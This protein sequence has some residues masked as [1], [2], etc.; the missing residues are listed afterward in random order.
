MAKIKLQGHASGSGIITLT[1]PNTSTDRVI[2]LPDATA[3]IATTTD[4]AA[5]LP[6]ITDGGNATAITIDSSERVSIG[7]TANP[8]SSSLHAKNGLTVAD[9]SLVI[10]KPDNNTKNWR[11]LPNNNLYD[12]CIQCTTGTNT[13]ETT[14]ATSYASVLELRH[15]GRGLSQFTAKAWANFN[16]TG[17]PAFRDSHNFSSLTDYATGFA[18]CNFT[19]AMANANYCAVASGDAQNTW[20]GAGTHA[21]VMN[22]AYVG[23]YHVENNGTVDTNIQSVLVF[24][25]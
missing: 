23:V 13:N 9:G 19:N 11:F 4:V 21:N 8:H 16:M 6:S 12:L 25:D 5:R 7:T 18:R 15:D 24:G 17:T 2:S 22:T 14:Q 10:S 20:Q 1:A 3:T